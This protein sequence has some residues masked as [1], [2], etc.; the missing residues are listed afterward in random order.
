MMSILIM[1]LFL[2]PALS[3]LHVGF[4]SN[5]KPPHS[6]VFLLALVNNLFNRDTFCQITR[7][8]DVSAFQHSHVVAQQLQGNGE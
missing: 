4:T 3:Y 5:K 2:K 7:L 6:A 8:V 1:N